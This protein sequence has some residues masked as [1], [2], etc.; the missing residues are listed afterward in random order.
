LKPVFPACIK[1]GDGPMTCASTGLPP[2]RL[3]AMLS[4]LRSPEKQVDPSPDFDLPSL[5]MVAGI[6][7]TQISASYLSLI[8]SDARR[9]AKVH[10]RG[11]FS[12][13]GFPLV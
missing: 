2:L 12:F 3:I 8:I 9:W 7:L 11:G 13:E 1:T 5:N 10:A 4:R 6:C